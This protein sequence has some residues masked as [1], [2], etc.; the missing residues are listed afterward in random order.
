M[1]GKKEVLIITPS[2]MVAKG[3][4]S[5]L[6]DMG[7][8]RVSGILTDLGRGDELR[9]KNMDMDLI[10]R[11]PSVLGSEARSGGK[12][13]LAGFSD[14]PV[15]ALVTSVAD[16]ETLRQYD[17]CVTLL[18]APNVLV[19]KLRNALEDRRE[20]PRSEGSE[21]SAREKEILICVAKGMLNKEIADLYNLSIYTVITHRKNITRKTGIKTVAGLTVYALLNNLIDI[22]SVE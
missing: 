3:I 20:S 19:K 10:I 1:T 5:I 4:E 12:S 8:F 7:E 13:Y 15:L 21:L 22:N 9:L 14:A 6:N 17:G 2:V 16:E 18:D 11:D